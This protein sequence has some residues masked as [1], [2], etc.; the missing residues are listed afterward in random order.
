MSSN[1]KSKRLTTNVTPEQFENIRKNAILSG[2]SPNAIGRFIREK[3]TRS[4]DYVEQKVS[5]EFPEVS[6]DTHRQIQ[7]AVTNLN[8]LLKVLHEAKLAGTHS[9]EIIEQVNGNMRLISEVSKAC[10]ERAD[11]FGGKNP[12]ASLARFVA[13]TC[14]NK[15]VA[16]I[17][18]FKKQQGAQ[19]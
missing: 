9:S 7:G 14:D 16:K 17:V 18:A 12:S 13:Y 4:F 19:S 15:M 2:Y 3:L 5:I 10:K 11:F 1:N 8:Q 6:A